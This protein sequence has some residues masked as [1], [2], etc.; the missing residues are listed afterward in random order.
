[1]N[2]VT[3]FPVDRLELVFA[4][5]FWAYA[6]EKRGEID[7]FFAALRRKAPAVWNGRV[8]LLHRHAL[9][10]GVFRGEYLE[11][12]YASFAFWRSLGRPAAGVQDCF[13]AAAIVAAD[14]GVLLGVMNE[15]TA[16]AGRVYFPCGTPDP[17]DIVDGRVDLDLS[18]ARELREETGLEVA[19][20][21]AAPGWTAVVD[22]N[23][24]MQV[25]I[26]RS[27]E[28]AEALRARIM[29]HLAAET[30]PELADIRIV[31]NRDDFDT[32]IPSFF[33]AFLAH[34]F[35]GAIHET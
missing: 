17:A 22:G 33:T 16:Q 21:A 23:L 11:I 3:I 5:R 28:N 4:P 27:S 8:L 25:K 15:N 13:G 1:M 34:Y 26:L 20:F 10:A 29:R 9:S 18:V 31:R 30:Q 7:D 35:S 24:V 12:D 6:D 32:A 14:G 2:G 19:D